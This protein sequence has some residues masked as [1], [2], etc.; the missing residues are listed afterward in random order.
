MQEKVALINAPNNRKWEYILSYNFT[1]F[2]HL[3]KILSL[4]I[5]VVKIVSLVF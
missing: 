4:L 3:K 5:S 1:N 2:D